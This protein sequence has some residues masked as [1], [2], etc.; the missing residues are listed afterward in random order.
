MKENVKISSNYRVVT[1]VSLSRKMKAC[2]EDLKEIRV[3]ADKLWKKMLGFRVTIE[4][5]PLVLIV[6]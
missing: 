5:L 2:Y 4:L 1:L 3:D 6:S